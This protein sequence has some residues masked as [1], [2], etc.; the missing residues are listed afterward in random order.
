MVGI[1]VYIW[2]VVVVSGGMEGQ[3]QTAG[4]LDL[5]SPGL[6]CT[7]PHGIMCILAAALADTLPHFPSP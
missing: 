6:C 1:S 2:A 5:L 4:K 3:G 7:P